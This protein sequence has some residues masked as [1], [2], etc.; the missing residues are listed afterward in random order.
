MGPN[1]SSFTSY[2][3]VGPGSL[4]L[5]GEEKDTGGEDEEGGHRPFASG[6]EEAHLW[7]EQAS[8]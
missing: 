4:V 5:E 8:E 2:L 3:L 1:P 6:Q 7:K